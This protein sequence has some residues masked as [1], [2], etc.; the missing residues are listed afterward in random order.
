M[1]TVGWAA[2]TVWVELAVLAVQVML[3]P[4]MALA[5]QAGLAVVM[6]LPSVRLEVWNEQF[7]DLSGV[8]I[9]D[10]REPVSWR[11]TPSAWPGRKRCPGQATDQV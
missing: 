4:S 3:T 8:Q 5:V 10:I 6:V 7:S 11:A 2:L 1:L 9:E